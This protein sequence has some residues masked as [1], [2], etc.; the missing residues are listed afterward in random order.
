MDDEKPSTSSK[1]DDFLE[2]FNDVN[3][4]MQQAL[5]SVV[6]AVKSSNDL[7]AAGDDFDYYSSFSGVRDFLDVEGKR[8]LHIIQTLMRFHNVKG[9]LERSGHDASDLEDKF[10]IIMDANDQILERVG[11]YLDEAAGIKKKE[12]NLV[13]ASATPKLTN[14]ASWNKKTSSVNSPTSSGY[15]LLSARNIQ[16][17]QLKFKDKADNSNTPFIPKIKV[18]PNAVKSL[19]DSMRLPEDVTPENLDDPSFTYPHPY[20]EELGVFKPTPQQL[21]VGDPQKPEP[22]SEC[23]YTMITKV[24]DLQSLVKK[25]SSEA[26][27]AVDLEAH[28]YRSFQGFVCLM[29]ISTRREDFLIDT[30]ELRHELPALNEVFTDPNIVKV[31]H[32]ANMDIEWL[33]R[34][35][36]LY[37]VNMFDTGQAARVLGHN[38]FS[39]AYLMDHYCGVNPNKQYQLADWRIRPLPQELIDYAREDTHYLLYIYDRM[40]KELITRGNEHKNLLISVLQRSTEVCAKVYKKNVFREDDYLEMYR[41]SKKVFNSQQ[42]AALQKLYAWRDRLA[43]QEDE[44]HSYVLPNHMLLQ[45]A[46]I[47][48]RERQGVF[49]CCNPIPP[50]VRQFLPEIHGFILEARE[51]PLVKVKPKE[52]SQ[53]SAYHHPKYDHSSLL[54]CPHDLSHQHT[55]VDDAMDIDIPVV[56]DV[57]M[58]TSMSSLYGTNNSG[59]IVV[60]K[61]KP[62]LSVLADK[63]DRVGSNGQRIAAAIKASFLNPFIM[64]LPDDDDQGSSIIKPRRTKQVMETWKL[65]HNTVKRK[66]SEVSPNSPS[67][68]PSAPP[69]KRAKLDVMSPPPVPDMSLKEVL[70]KHKKAARDLQEFTES[71]KDKKEKKKKSKEP[72]EVTPF[73]YSQVN[74]KL[75]QGEHS[76]KKQKVFDPSAEMRKKNK[77]QKIQKPMMSTSKSQ[78]SETFNRKDKHHG[79]RKWP[80]M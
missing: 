30:L 56:P 35:F 26:E 60:M 42:L 48:P 11:N 66:A 38:K 64:Y 33:Q 20:Q 21:E 25:L 13:L 62:L 10:D 5:Q 18:K 8:I 49:A 73:D 39:L 45:I 4:Y 27:L 70:A 2:G 55:S 65:R 59:R 6:Q 23:P 80:K 1:K 61:D 19:E 53:P 9:N 75:F 69:A 68:A 14:S 76:A 58:V 15:R 16:R 43:R 22:V 17:P 12:D 7:P 50:L 57:T 78:K 54:T 44:S 47:L 36:G 41:K 46:E 71:K 24:E 63:N 32:G 77:G 74:P 34:D 51:T 3:Q 72:V 29:Q 37:V 28:S 79:Q 67:P 31:F 40:R 52:K